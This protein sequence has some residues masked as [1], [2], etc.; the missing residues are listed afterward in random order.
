MEENYE[1]KESGPSTE[2]AGKVTYCNIEMANNGFVVRFDVRDKKP[3]MGDM[4]H[5]SSTTKTFVFEQDQEDEA[6]EYYKKMKMLE[7][8]G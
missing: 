6:W 1:Q 4:E 8:K 5:C 2:V 7:I 3:G